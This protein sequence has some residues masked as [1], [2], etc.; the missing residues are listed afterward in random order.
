MKFRSGLSSAGTWLAMPRHPEKLRG[1]LFSSI[2][3]YNLL[4]SLTVDFL[5]FCV[6]ITE[7]MVDEVR[8]NETVL[9]DLNGNF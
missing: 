4:I 8:K 1:I 5:F 2:L 9:E 6:T 7:V 3:G